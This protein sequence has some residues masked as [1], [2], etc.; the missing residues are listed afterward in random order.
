MY[1]LACAVHQ[2][3]Q[4]IHAR[5]PVVCPHAYPRCFQSLPFLRSHA[6][7]ATIVTLVDTATGGGD[8]V[9]AGVSY[10]KTDIVPKIGANVFFFALSLLF[11]LIFLLWWARQPQGER[12][13]RHA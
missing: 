1:G 10:L 3:G 5:A 8:L 6:S 11:L 9:T 13:R 4:G 2:N 7:T 12:S